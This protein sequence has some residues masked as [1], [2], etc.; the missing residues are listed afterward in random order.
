GTRTYT[1]VT[2]TTK[3]KSYVFLLH[4]TGMLNLKVAELPQE[5]REKLGYTS[6]PPATASSAASAWAHRELA[7]V[8]LPQLSSLEQLWQ[9]RASGR[10]AGLPQLSSRVLLV[11]AVVM[12]GLYLFCCYCGRLICQK[13]GNDPGLLIWIP[14]LQIFPLLR[15]A[16]MTRWWFF[17]FLV[18]IL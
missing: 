15:S 6:K 8:Q 16:G 5:V 17:V 18:P 1:N 4:S 11:G 13:T 3:A 10:L 14:L 12:I 7:Q 2:V 9:A